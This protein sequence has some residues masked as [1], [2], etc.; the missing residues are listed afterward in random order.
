M[1]AAVRRPP[2][3]RALSH[4]GRHAHT[5]RSDTRIQTFP[6]PG[7][8]GWAKVGGG[9]WASIVLLVMTTALFEQVPRARSVQSLDQPPAVWLHLQRERI[10]GSG[11]KH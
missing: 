7:P 8:G 9:L 3:A 1:P 5:Q 10:C 6:L 2:R 4:P 11:H